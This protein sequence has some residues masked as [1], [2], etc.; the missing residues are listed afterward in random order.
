M[1]AIRP[2]QDEKQIE[3]CVQVL[4]ASFGTV[5]QEFGLT[6]ANA[7]TNPAFTTTEKLKAHTKK[8]A[9]L[10]GLFVGGRMVGCV[11]VEKSKQREDVFFVERLAVLPKERHKGY[12]RELMQYSFDMI[13]KSGGR[14]ASVGLMNNN[15]VLKNWYIGQGFVQTCVKMLEHLPFEVCF[16][17]VALSDR[18]PH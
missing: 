8:P 6:E 17:S 2:I 1:P 12:G 14:V 3:E 7:P 11:A 16:M 9:S 18:Q 13:V 10:Y 5:A 4:R 15:K